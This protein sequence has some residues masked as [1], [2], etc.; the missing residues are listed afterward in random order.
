MTD[1]EIIDAHTHVLRSEEHGRE[2]FGYF[3]SRNPRSGHPAEPVAYGTVDELR[4]MMGRNAVSRANILMFTWSGQYW[5]DGRYTLPD[6][7][8]RRAAAAEELRR[9]IVER[10]RDNNAWAARTVARHPELTYFCGVDAVLMDEQTMLTEVQTR[11]A[12]GASGVK[13]VPRDMRI[14]G[15]DPRLRPL[16]DW[17]M[18]RGVP[19]LTESSGH[20]GAFGQPAGFAKALADFPR[21]TLV[22]AHCGHDPVFGEGADAEVVELAHRYDNVCADLSLRL[23]E[24]ADGKVTAG[25]MAAH[26][27]RI[28]VDRVLYGSNYVLAELLQQVEGAGR[29]QL[30]RT[31]SQLRAFLELPLA[32]E[33]KAAVAA[34]NFRRITGG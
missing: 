15:D 21:L 19:V 32:D 11:I 5:R 13:I 12:D 27:R 31:E 23:L 1:M 14:R 25:Q 28:G 33:E 3:L 22:F 10:I 2:A 18:S 24:V 17:C 16:F 20:K 26:I 7:G 30:A 6:G 9:R 4:L 29:P 8:P 34:G